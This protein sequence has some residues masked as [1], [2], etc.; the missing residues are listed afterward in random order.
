MLLFNCQ[1]R[2][3]ERDGPSVIQGSFGLTAG[4]AHAVYELPEGR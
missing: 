1:I 4:E 3:E 2:L